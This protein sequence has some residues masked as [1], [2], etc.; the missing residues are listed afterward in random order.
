MCISSSC[1]FFVPNGSIYAGFESDFI[2]LVTPGLSNRRCS[3]GPHD[4]GTF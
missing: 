1:Y 4:D 2:L 3:S